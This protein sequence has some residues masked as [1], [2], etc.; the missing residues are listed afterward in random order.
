MRKRLCLL[1]SVSLMVL[2]AALQGGEPLFV[3]VKIDGPAHDPARNTFWYGPFSE[4]ASVLDVDGDGRLDIAAGRNWYQAPDWIKHENFR[5]GAETNGPETD[6]NSEFAMD[7]NRDGR[8]D[9]VASGWMRVRGAFWYENPGRTGAKWKAY[10]IHS[11]QSMEGVIHGDIDGDGDEDI[12]VNHW[13]LAPGQGMTWLEHIDREPW[14]KEHVIGTQ[15][16]THGNGLGDINGDGRV[17]IVT[18]VGWYEA[19]PKPAEQPWT[20]HADYRFEGGPASHPI[21]VYDFNGDGLNDILIGA[22]HAYGLAWLEQKVEPG[23]KRTFTHR[24]VERDFGGF[25]TMALGDLN[26]DGKPELVSGKRLFPHHG[27]DIGEFDPLFVFWYKIRNG[28]FERHVLSYNHLPWYPGQ[29]TTNPPPNGAIGV[30]M[31]LN[32]RDMDGDGRNDIVCAGKSG[33]YV[34]YNRGFT[35]SPRGQNLLPPETTY[36]SWVEWATPASAGLAP[37]FNGKDLKGWQPPAAHWVVENGVLTLKDSTDRK[38]H[39]DG[40]LW[41]EKTYGDFVLDLE[42]KVWEGANS[43]VFLRTTGLKNPVQTGIEI[44]VGSSAPGRPLGRGSVGGIYDL[45]APAKDLLKPDDWNRYVITCKG[46]RI[47]VALNGEPVSE[48]DLDLWRE[49]Q[50]NPDGSKNKF[51]RPLKEFARKGYIGF[52]DH[53]TPVSYRNIRIRTLDAASVR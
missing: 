29:K 52:Q 23:G 14:F 4:C 7:V 53:G 45:V 46:S 51:N 49:A 44:Q 43:G 21:L 32:I 33:L 31:K 6:D 26:G 40:Y 17:D 19:P 25:H 35:P 16:E 39:N 11:A 48:A 15:G 36:P 20:F 2:F 18:P 1:L 3:P 8:M 12:L 10:R 24:W 27:R 37:L 42:F 50:K 38:E 41:T 13:S 34:F 22:A 28:G 5:E 47:S 30:G 9:I